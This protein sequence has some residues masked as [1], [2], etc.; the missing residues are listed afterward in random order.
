VIGALAHTAAAAAIGGR[1]GAF[2]RAPVGATAFAMGGAGSA[3]PAYLCA[4]WNPALLSASRTRRID[5]GMGVRSLG[6]MESFASMGF[7]IPPRVGMG[8]AVLYRGDPFLDDLHDAE[9]NPLG[10]GAY[11][12]LT[13]KTGL[14]Y[15]INRKWSIG[16][17]IA[18]CYQ[19]LPTAI[20]ADNTLENSTVTGI[21][22]IDLACSWKPRPDLSLAL[23][24]RNLNASMDWEITTTGFDMGT[25]ATDRVLPEFVLAG[26]LQRSLY[27]K[28]FIWT[29]DLVGY[30]FDGDWDRLERAETVLNN[31]FE[32][33]TWETFYLRAGI[34]DL[35]IDSKLFD[36]ASEYF[37]RAALRISAGFALRFA[38]VKRGELWI[39]YG[40]ATDKAW[41]GIDQIL[42]V[43]YSF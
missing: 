27:G 37:N 41:A 38:R 35:S 21:G 28:P 14:S 20:N 16:A 29:S 39:N 8:I 13:I 11:T 12:T 26:R 31:G 19:S 33:Q 15:F 10:G 22:G 42:D 34:G 4:W 43:S 40:A 23:L 5:L 7:R 9:E 32:W 1:S 6:R 24:V 18:I 25:R 17:A 30:V 3:A 36:D 2:L